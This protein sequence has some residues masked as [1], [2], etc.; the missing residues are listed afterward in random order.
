MASSTCSSRS[1]QDRE[2]HS[3]SFCQER[4]EGSATPA[5]LMSQEQ[6][7][8]YSLSYVAA[9]GQEERED[10]ESCYYSYPGPSPIPSPPAPGRRVG[11]TSILLERGEGG[12]IRSIVRLDSLQPPAI[13]YSRDAEFVCESA[14]TYHNYTA[15]R[16]E[17]GCQTEVVK[18][19]EGSSQTAKVVSRE[20]GS[21]TEEEVVARRRQD[22]RVIEVP[23]EDEHC[24]D[25]TKV[26]TGRQPAQQPGRHIGQAGR[27]ARIFL[28]CSFTV[29]LCTDCVEI[30]LGSV[31]PPLRLT[32]APA[33]W[34]RLHGT[35][36]RL[37]LEP[38]PKTT[39][40]E[41]Y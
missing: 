23:V 3:S 20:E 35:Q 25:V 34:Q 12:D 37:H 41:K 6:E 32:A 26:I 22:S 2:E 29:R 8:S 13:L 38:Q 18:R 11:S 21:Q 27:C 24:H 10:A 9:S 40:I 30:E 33:V 28:Q 4:E 16:R 7:W 19:Q 5:S 15:E 39:L 31:A 36:D 17:E 14:V 1:S